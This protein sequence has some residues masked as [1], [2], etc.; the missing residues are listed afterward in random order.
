MFENWGNALRFQQ[1]LRKEKNLCIWTTYAMLNL[2]PI[3]DAF[4][5]LSLRNGIGNVA[6]V[7]WI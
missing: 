2:W 4:G 5:Y 6:L 1:N 3:C 7:M